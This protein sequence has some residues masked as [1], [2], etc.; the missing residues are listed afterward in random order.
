[1]IKKAARL[2]FVLVLLAAFQAGC[3]KESP[4]ENLPD[5]SAREFAQ[6]YAR[7]LLLQNSLAPRKQREAALRSLYRK[8]KLDQ[9]TFE[10]ILHY[11][12]NHPERWLNVLEEA[13]MILDSLQTSNTATVKSK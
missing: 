6:L 1:L 10:R 7:S 11:Y 8:Y 3:G 9:E 4:D 2:F 12:Q 13:K 5:L